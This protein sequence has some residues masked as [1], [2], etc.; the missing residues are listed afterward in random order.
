ME[1]ILDLVLVPAHGLPVDQESITKII[2]EQLQRTPAWVRSD[3]ASHDPALLER[4]EDVLA[5]MISA[6][7][8]SGLAGWSTSDNPDPEIGDP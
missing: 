3:L 5:A 7:L 6:A 4:A 8:L 2:R 1:T